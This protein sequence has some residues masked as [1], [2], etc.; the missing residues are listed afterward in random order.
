MIHPKAIKPSYKFLFV[1]I[2]NGIIT[3]IA[4]NILSDS[5]VDVIS[6]YGMKDAAYKA[7]KILKNNQG[8]NFVYSCK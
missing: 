3:I 2:K 7:V 8:V 6:A 4:K 1:L 5:N